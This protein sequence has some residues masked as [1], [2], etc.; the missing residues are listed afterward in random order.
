MNETSHTNCLFCN[1]P[2]SRVIADDGLAYAVRDGYPVTELHTLV[3]TRRHV[4]SYFDLDG[5]ELESCNDLLG[6][7]QREILELDTTVT[8]FNIGVN[9]GKDAGQSVFHCHIHLIPR[10]AGDVSTPR[11]GV[12][13]I[14]PGRQAY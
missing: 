2:E 1:I 5:P 11:G 3:I 10:R 4:S 14:I 9:V 8:G 6:R 12:R 7:M 13:G